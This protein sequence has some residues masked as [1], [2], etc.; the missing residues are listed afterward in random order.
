V[1]WNVL[2]FLAIRATENLKGLN[3]KGGIS[4]RKNRTTRRERRYPPYLR[5]YVRQIRA[6]GQRSPRLMSNPDQKKKGTYGEGE[7]LR[8]PRTPRLHRDNDVVR[9]AFCPQSRL[10]RNTREKSGGPAEKREGRPQLRFQSTI[11][12]WRDRGKGKGRKRLCK[13]NEKRVKENETRGWR[14]G[15]STK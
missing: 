2:P 13:I 3:K 14:C 5:F 9:L 10:G 1:N 4:M 8:L 6:T 12:K 7:R 15:G 11:H